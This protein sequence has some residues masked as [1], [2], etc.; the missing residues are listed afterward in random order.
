[1]GNGSALR[2]SGL[3]D[4]VIGCFSRPAPARPGHGRQHTQPHMAAQAKACTVAQLDALGTQ[5]GQ[6]RGKLRQR[7]TC[8]KVIGLMTGNDLPAQ[9]LAQRQLLPSSGARSSG[10]GPAIAAPRPSPRPAAWPRHASPPPR[11]APAHSAPAALPLWHAGGQSHRQRAHRH[12]QGLVRRPRL[13]DS[14]EIAL[15]RFALQA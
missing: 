7:Q 12:A 2:P 5:A 6:R 14:I 3:I 1:M 11:M 8:D 4:K 15:R 10:C 13:P 9:S